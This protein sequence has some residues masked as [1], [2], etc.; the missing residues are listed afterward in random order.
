MPS[1]PVHRRNREARSCRCRRYERRTHA[2]HEWK[3]VVLDGGVP[4]ELELRDEPPGQRHFIIADPNGVLVD[5]ITPIEPTAG[6][7]ALY[8][9]DATV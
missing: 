8:A 7:A 6:F 4:A 5:V 9:E 1:W 3:R 2:R